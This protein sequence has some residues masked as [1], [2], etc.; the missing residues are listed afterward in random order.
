MKP[1]WV[2]WDIM[3]KP[4]YLGGMGFRDIEI[5]NLAL[6][7]HQAWMLLVDPYSLSARILK[8]AYSQIVVSW[9]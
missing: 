4:K 8:S 7:A 1:A 9:K 6:L 2:S 3:T 5:F